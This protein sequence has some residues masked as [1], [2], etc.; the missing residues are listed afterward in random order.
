MIETSSGL[1]MTAPVKTC[2]TADTEK[3]QGMATGA[4][5]TVTLT[6]C[7]QAVVICTRADLHPS[8]DPTGANRQLGEHACH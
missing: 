6:S 1:T 3:G 5:S 4:C 7:L 2:T 8:A